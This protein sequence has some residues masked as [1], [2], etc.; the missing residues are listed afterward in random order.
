MSVSLLF[1]DLEDEA[2]L[3]L[4]E[5]LEGFIEKVEKDWW[6][7][8]ILN[9]LL[10]HQQVY[11][12]ENEFSSLDLNS[13]VSVFV[14]NNKSFLERKLIS[15]HEYKDLAMKIRYIR[16]AV[17]HMPGPIEIQLT[18]EKIIYF[19]MAYK[20]FFRKFHDLFSSEQPLVFKRI[21][22]NLKIQMIRFLE[23][24]DEDVDV[25]KKLGDDSN[26][27]ILGISKKIDMIYEK[28]D[29]N[30]MSEFKIINDNLPYE[31]SDEITPQESLNL[32]EAKDILI[33]LRENF[34]R[35]Y[36]DI[37]REEG[38]LTN[39]IIAF[40]IDNKIFEKEIF[41][42]APS[43]VIGKVDTRQFEKI[44]DILSVIKRVKFE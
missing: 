35:E 10:P 7:H 44:E 3:E 39:S 14:F 33:G 28:L 34:R 26:D 27:K 22:E 17:A 21:N 19:L 6:D 4:I 40:I 36:K 20:L 38:I 11:V 9:S 16:N 32:E 18:S 5:V 8:Y 13:L 1:K 25:Y 30:K 24:H 31:S 42:K 41:L 15:S 43:E 37:P 2:R 12:K 29:Q 23:A